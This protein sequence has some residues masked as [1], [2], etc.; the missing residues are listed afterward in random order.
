MKLHYMLAALLACVCAA[1][2]NA[3]NLDDFGLTGVEACSDAEAATV[4]GQGAISTGMA[5]MQIMVF[6][7]VSGS[8]FNFQ[9]SSINLS[10]EV[11]FGPDAPGFSEAVTESSV[12]LSEM[13]FAVDA[14]VIESGGFTIGALGGG[15]T[16]T[17]LELAP[18][19]PE[20]EHAP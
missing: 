16:G 5:S 3:A 9:S 1:P 14:F 10:D 17:M 13:S 19:E 2:V 15:F 8:S 4:R 7:Y 12:S 6:D 11:S 20:I 18:V